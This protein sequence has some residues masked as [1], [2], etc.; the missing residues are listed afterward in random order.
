MTSLSAQSTGTALRAAAREAMTHAYAPYSRF[1]VGAAGLVDDGRI[2]TGCNVENASYGLGL[3]A[4]CGWSRRCARTGG[5][6]LVA[7]R[8]RGRRRAAADAVRPVPAAAV[9]ARRRR[10][11]SSR[12]C[13]WASC[14]CARCCRTPSAPTTSSRLRSGTDPEAC[15]GRDRRH[16]HQA[17]RRRALR[18]ADR[19][20]DRRLHPRRGAPTSRCP[21]C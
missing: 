12:P 5:G 6:R 13:R 2:V 7:R 21:R 10:T 1:P 18:R 16:P 15:H 9:G 17:G 8:L 14:R 20:G 4:E 3:C 11:C 19:L